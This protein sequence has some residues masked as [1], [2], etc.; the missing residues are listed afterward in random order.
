MKHAYFG[1]NLDLIPYKIVK[2]ILGET[3]ESYKDTIQFVKVDGEID[4][5]I[6]MLYIHP[7]GKKKVF[8]AAY[9]LKNEK[10][11][12][13]I[14]KNTLLE[15]LDSEIEK[16]EIIEKKEFQKSAK[17]V[18]SIIGLILGIILTYLILKIF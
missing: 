12:S 4:K 14:D 1:K 6:L 16:I 7:I 5:N 13:C 11:I 9:D 10:I 17:I 3:Y 8:L 18:I 2:N 15:I